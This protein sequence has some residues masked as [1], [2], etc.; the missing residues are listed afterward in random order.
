MRAIFK[1]VAINVLLTGGAATANAQVAYPNYVNPSSISPQYGNS[2]I[3][4]PACV[5]SGPISPNAAFNTLVQPAPGSGTP[6]E[7]Q[8]G[9]VNVL[10]YGNSIYNAAN[11]YTDSKIASVNGG[12]V[13]QSSLSQQLAFVSSGFDNAIRRQNTFLSQGIAMASAIEI[14]PPNPGDRFAINVGGA[15]YNG[16]GAGSVSATVRVADN[17]LGYVGYARSL[18]QNLVKGGFSVSIH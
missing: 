10:D 18:N 6:Y 11:A 15:G 9:N 7:A 12:G 8:F 17:V 16:Q 1:L 14:L 3:N 2:C 4:N 13:S 5:T